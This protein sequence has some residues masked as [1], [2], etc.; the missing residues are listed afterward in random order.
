[1]LKVKVYIIINIHKL[2]VN[3]YYV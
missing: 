3:I 1:M 2:Y